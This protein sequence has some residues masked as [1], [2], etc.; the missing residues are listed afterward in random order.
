M[1]FK[2]VNGGRGRL[3]DSPSKSSLPHLATKEGFDSLITTSLSGT[4]TPPVPD[5]RSV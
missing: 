1:S 2:A 4:H 5:G 3:L